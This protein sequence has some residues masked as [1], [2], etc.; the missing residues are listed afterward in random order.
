MI[1]RISS[2]RSTAV[3][4]V[5]DLLRGCRCVSYTVLETKKTLQMVPK[6]DLNIGDSPRVTFWNPVL[7]NLPKISLE[8][9]RGA[10]KTEALQDLFC[11]RYAYYGDVWPVFSRS[12]GGVEGE[13]KTMSEK[14]CSPK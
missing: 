12:Y 8:S 6:R 14:T 5:G 4:N 9:S 1:G 7:T 10:K 13:E 11:L 2:I 3:L